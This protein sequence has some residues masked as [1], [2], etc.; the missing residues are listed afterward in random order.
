M[1]G[2]WGQV[3]QFIEKWY[4]ANFI[5]GTNP[6]MTFIGGLVYGFW[7][8]LLLSAIFCL[9]TDPQW[10]HI[11]GF[12]HWSPLGYIHYYFFFWKTV[13]TVTCHC[14]WLYATYAWEHMG[15]IG[16]FWRHVLWL[17]HPEYF[18]GVGNS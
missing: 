6:I 5:R 11:E 16:R 9:V 3:M 14:I 8:P 18:D 2:H 4:W 15:A 17:D 1:I 12:A 7:I 13:I 10:Q